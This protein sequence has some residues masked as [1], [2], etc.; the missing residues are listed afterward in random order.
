MIGS[1]EQY[2]QT[3][4]QLKELE[5][6]QL[7]FP[8]RHD[9]VE[10]KSRLTELQS[11]IAL[12]LEQYSPIRTNLQE[13]NI[14][15]PAPFSND[16]LYNFHNYLRNKGL[17]LTDE[18]KVYTASIPM[19]QIA[20]INQI[21]GDDATWS[22]CLNG[23][24]LKRLDRALW[25]LDED[26]IY[27]VDAEPKS[28]VSFVKV[29]DK[30]FVTEG[31]HRTIVSRFF[32]HFNPHMFPDSPLKN[33]T[34]R[35]FY[36]DR[37]FIEMQRQIEALANQYPELDFKL[38]HT[39]DVDDGRF[40]TI[41]E[42]NAYNKMGCFTRG[43]YQSVI[44]ALTCPSLREKWHSMQT[45]RHSNI[46]DFI[47]YSACLAPYLKKISAIIRIKPSKYKKSR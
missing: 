38:Q 2:K 39:T 41:V 47:T 25:E 32:E 27:Y 12:Y 6:E 33:A 8:S 43:Q 3:R 37:E 29:E 13:L 15:S 19:D 16:T 46:Y 9:P 26:P 44:S 17:H 23:R 42:R 22:D 14:E 10:L 28:G 40:L 4:M 31:K 35:E 1:V 5:R 18:S 7:Y 34:V 45:I 21:Y 11:S 24:W 20:G 30:Y 36:V